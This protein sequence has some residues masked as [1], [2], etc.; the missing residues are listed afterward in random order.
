MILAFVVYPVTR[1]IYSGWTTLAANFPGHGVLP[2]LTSGLAFF[3]TFVL[4]GWIL[5]TAPVRWF[6]MSVAKLWRYLVLKRFSALENG[7]DGKDSWRGKE[8]A[9]AEEGRFGDEEYAPVFSLGVVI[10]DDG[11]W[12]TVFLI[13]P[14]GGTSRL[15]YV[16]KKSGRLWPTGRSIQKHAETFVTFGSGVRPRD[17]LPNQK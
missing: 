12:V 15:L 1:G 4:L 16:R 11:A 17:F 5:G 9:Y 13:V 3:A 7:K 6:K 8:V 10:D 14:P 2:Y